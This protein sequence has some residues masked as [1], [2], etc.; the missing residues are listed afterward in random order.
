MALPSRKKQKEYMSNV[1]L[2]LIK[3]KTKTIKA[4]PVGRLLRVEG[5]PE[6]KGR[7]TGKRTGVWSLKRN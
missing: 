2:S 5:V 1:A 3:K 4:T 6:L 7:L